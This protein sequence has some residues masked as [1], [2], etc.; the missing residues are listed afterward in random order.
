VI[1]WA[2]G[3]FLMLRSL[4][5]HP[6]HAC[7]DFFAQLRSLGMMWLALCVRKNHDVRSAWPDGGRVTLVLRRIW[8]GQGWEKGSQADAAQRGS[9]LTH[10]ERR[11][12]Y[13]A[14]GLALLAAVAN[15]SGVQRGEMSTLVSA[16]RLTLR[17]RS[18]APLRG[19]L[20]R[21]AS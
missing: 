4:G 11:C 6:S 5:I 9:A 21:A 16:P 13:S 12:Y 10:Q 18:G 3:L 2:G 7:A 17:R 19:V 20:R 8:C 1:D 15:V 14:V